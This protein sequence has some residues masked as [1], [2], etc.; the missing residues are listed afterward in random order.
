MTAP[1]YGKFGTVLDP[2]HEYADSI[3]HYDIRVYRDPQ[4]PVVTLPVAN[5]TAGDAFEAP[6]I[7]LPVSELDEKTITSA[8]FQISI[9]GAEFEAY[10]N[11]A[12]VGAHADFRVAYTTSCD[13]VL[14]ANVG[15]I[16]IDK[17]HGEGA[18]EA[19]LCPGETYQFIDG[20]SEEITADVV[21]VVTT[22]YAKFGQGTELFAD[23]TVTYTLTV[24]KDPI[25]PNVDLGVDRITAGDEI[26][27][28][29]IE[30][31]AAETDTVAVANTYWTIRKD[32]GTAEN[33]N[34]EPI[35]AH[36]AI[37]QYFVE[38]ECGT[39]IDGQEFAILVD[40]YIEESTVE[41]TVCAGHQYLTPS[42]Q[43]VTVTTSAQ[44]DDVLPFDKFNVGSTEFAEQITHYIITVYS[45]PE[46]SLN[47]VL[48]GICGE[49]L[50]LPEPSYTAG[51]DIAEIA[52]IVWQ[53]RSNDNGAYADY[54]GAPVYGTEAVVRYVATTSCGTTY[55]S[56]PMT[57]VLEVPIYTADDVE[58]GVEKYGWLLLIN[59]TAVEATINAEIEESW[60]YWY[61]VVGEVDYDSHETNDEFLGNGF[62]YTTDHTL[63]GTGQY[64]A[65]I[66][67][68]AS[69][70]AC[71]SM[72]RSQIFLFNTERQQ[73]RLQS[74][75]LTRD[76]DVTVLN[77]DTESETTVRVVDMTGQ[78][79]YQTRTIGTD[80]LTLPAQQ[81]GYYMVHVNGGINRATLKF[82]VK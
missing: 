15:A 77:L 73:I 40:K 59:K 65:V 30:I 71:G 3:V 44:F 79:I 82:V 16:N 28:P 47:D 53:I 5:L 60:I 32:Y 1:F 34:G 67:V 78:T 7:T 25:L 17:Y 63:T 4:L 61:K 35:V 48:T 74:T 57:V 42:G 19:T 64:Y 49:A 45:M 58:I 22:D 18:E 81:S 23:T 38:T 6:E 66:D 20:S 43:L 21:K 13:D 26:T 10:D 41:E 37:L 80:V 52:S 56:D 27:L 2:N 62:Y 24:L 54:N 12:I 9:D 31:R 75:M 14:Y 70:G 55:T 8:E 11:T 39:V 72:F 33:Y 29:A 51:E 68:P 76:D 46:F 69:G 50:E 36:N